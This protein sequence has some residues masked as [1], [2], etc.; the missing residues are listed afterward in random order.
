MQTR[1]FV[2]LIVDM[3]NDGVSAVSVIMCSAVVPTLVPR[4]WVLHIVSLKNR[5][6][7]SHPPGNI[8]FMVYT[9]F[10]TPSGLEI[11]PS[12]VKWYSR[13]CADDSSVE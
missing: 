11:S 3:D 5:I 8:P 1:L 2:Q 13:V 10:S 7:S 12:T 4:L 9:R 6:Q